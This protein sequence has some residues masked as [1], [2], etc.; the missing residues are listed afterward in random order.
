MANVK[1]ID[2]QYQDRLNKPSIEYGI[3]AQQKRPRPGSRGRVA[4]QTRVERGGSVARRG[5]E[6]GK[7]ASISNT[8]QAK[9]GLSPKKAKMVQR[10][11]ALQMFLPMA[12]AYAIAY[13]AQITFAFLSFVFMGLIA[14]DES[15]IIFSAFFGVADFL[16]ISIQVLFAVMLFITWCIGCISL[17]ILVA[18]FKVRGLA[19]MS[20]EGQTFKYV[21][22]ILAPVF[23][24]FPVTNIIPITFAYA[25]LII[26]YPK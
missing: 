13:L 11:V 3:A 22:L 9:G 25:A 8:L 18:S 7:M 17:L 14:L 19:V 12:Y 16:G 5:G 6:R 1:P 15:S 23:Y 2:E 26:W 21:L 10:A 20:G 24:L 4:Q